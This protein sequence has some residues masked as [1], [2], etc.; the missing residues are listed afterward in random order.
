MAKKKE[1]SGPKIVLER[2]YNVP[3]RKGFMKSP[4]WKRT[5]KAINVLREFLEKHMK[6]EDIK[7]EKYLNLELWKHGIK[8]PPH[9]VKVMAKK[10]DKGI[11][12][13]E[14]AELPDYAK[15]EIEKE[16]K[17]KEEKEKKKQSEEKGTE[18]GVKD[19]L[20]GNEKKPE[21]KKESKEE[22]VKEEPKDKKVDAENTI[23][24]KL[25]DDKEEA[26]KVE[27]E[28]IKEL[29]KSKPQKEKVPKTGKQPKS[30]EA[31]PNAPMNK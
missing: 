22:K 23:I 13:A 4:K 20:G 29:K 8:N 16:K 5:K 9:H 12:R 10:D 31:R 30:V 17:A 19:A 11:V 26:K 21:E 15:K 1:D 3:L 14:L 25:D 18:I 28:E 24:D 27:A 7:I 2:E 6:S